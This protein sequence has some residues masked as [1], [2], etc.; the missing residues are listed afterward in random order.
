MSLCWRTRPSVSIVLTM[1]LL[2]TTS[3]MQKDFLLT[4]DACQKK[5]ICQI[6]AKSARVW[7][8]R[9]SFYDFGLADSKTPYLLYIKKNQNRGRA[10][11]VGS[12]SGELTGEQTLQNIHL[13]WCILLGADC[14]RWMKNVNILQQMCILEHRF[15]HNICSPLHSPQNEPMNLFAKLFNNFD[16]FYV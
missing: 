4:Y 8:S 9:H 5:L 3:F 12:F 1:Y 14:I 7:S 10:L 11:H 2:Y 13:L 6:S 16:F 15:L